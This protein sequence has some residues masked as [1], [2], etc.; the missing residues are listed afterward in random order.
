MKIYCREPKGN[1]CPKILKIYTVME[2][3]RVPLAIQVRSQM[4]PKV[5]IPLTNPRQSFLSRFFHLTLSQGIR[6]L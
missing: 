5:E 1:Q 6:P 2:R 3:L 4:I